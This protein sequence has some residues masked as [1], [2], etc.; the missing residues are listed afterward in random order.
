MSQQQPNLRITVVM[1]NELY[2]RYFFKYPDPF[3]VVTVDGEQTHT[4]AP[5]KA[6][7]NPFWNAAFDLVVTERSVISVQ[8]F[9]QRRFAKAHQGF[10]GVVNIMVPTVIDIRRKMTRNLT[11]Q[12]N[13]SNAED[14]VKGN[15]TVLLT[16]DFTPARPTSSFG[17]LLQQP[18][19]Q[20][21]VPVP[22][23]S[24]HSLPPS[25]PIQQK[26]GVHAGP[27]PVNSSLGDELGPLPPGWERRVD[28]FGRTFYVDHNARTTTWTRP[29]VNMPPAE[30][31][32]QQREIIEEQRRQHEA[33]SLPATAITASGSPLVEPAAPV[34]SDPPPPMPADAAQQQQ[35]Q[36]RASQDSRRDLSPESTRVQQGL[37]NFQLPAEGEE[38]PAGWERR[39]APNGQFYYVDHNT[40]S[41]TWTRPGPIRPRRQQA[42]QPQPQ[43]Q[44]QQQG[45]QQSQIV[46]PENFQTLVAESIKR[47][48]ELPNGFE[49]RLHSDGRIF[50]IDH[51]S[52][53]T[54]W[55]DPR[56]PSSVDSSVPQYKRDFQRK[57][58]YLRIQPE[59]RQRKGKI[60]IDIRR[61]S[62]FQDAFQNMMLMSPEELKRRLNIRF[63]G[64]EGLDYGGVAREFFFLMSHEC[65]SPAYCLFEYS[66]HDNYTLQIS[67][68]SHINPEHL[69]YF[70][71]IGRLIGVAIFHQKFVDAF[72]VS[73]FYK[74]ILGM[75]VNLEDMES[76][77]A[78]VYKNLNWILENDVTDLGSIFCVD[79]DKFGSIVEEELKPGGKNIDVSNENKAEYVDLLVKWRI[80]NR[81]Q[82]QM[83]AFCSGLFEIIPRSLLSIFDDRELEM[84]I[85][86]IAEIDVAD[87]QKHTVY[88]NYKPDDQ[89]IQWFWKCLQEEY[90][91]EKRA[92]LLQFSTGT[93]RVPVNG[94]KDLQGSDGPRLFCIERIT[95]T[96]ALPKS[97]TCFNRI[98]LPPYADYDTLV[99]KLTMAIEE[100]IGFAQE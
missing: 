57:L 56:L 74:Q 94:F 75:E 84:L 87:W 46:R 73:S 14:I 32:R 62:V 45:Q 20:S 50:F 29:P 65:F 79:D 37:A 96:Q 66:S 98:D 78:D 80:V 92:R 97:H 52:Q 22:S 89:V 25:T 67:P 64:E 86:G 38:L 90:D 18:Q 24:T 35:Q 69:Q 17:Q 39:I 5:V 28:A 2:K 13:P 3:A 99:R 49:M 31:E 36:R 54:T 44:P 23:E 19:G 26:S 8:V 100:T 40:R 33:R 43:P 91:D 63:D 9:D 48:G 7:L 51:N 93:S 1:A 83:E 15:V 72:F 11:V 58:A 41:T 16:T 34:A 6:S 68:H 77:D 4:T 70:K 12:L 61:Q 30:V 76:V 55:D 10:L 95:D 85:G 27:L 59:M 42:P 60:T 53:S 88:R 82:A 71:F 21:M 81:I 47:L